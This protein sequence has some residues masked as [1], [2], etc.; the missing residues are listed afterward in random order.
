[1]GR[2][3]LPPQ[4]NGRFCAQEGEDDGTSLIRIQCLLRTQDMSQVMMKLYMF[5][6]RM[7]E[8]PFHIAFTHIDYTY[9]NICSLTEIPSVHACISTHKT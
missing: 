3:K 8:C 5:C 2:L 7:N 4:K 9:V 6:Y 1:M